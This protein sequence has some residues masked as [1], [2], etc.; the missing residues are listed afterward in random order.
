MTNRCKKL[1]LVNYS[2]SI[3]KILPTKTGTPIQTLSS[4][5]IL[6]HKTGVKKKQ[7]FVNHFILPDITPEITSVEWIRTKHKWIATHCSVT[8]L[9]LN[10]LC[11][12]KSVE[13][14][15]VYVWKRV[16]QVSTS[17]KYN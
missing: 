6:R 5:D 10:R 14:D 17:L 11:R 2:H 9:L 13:L 12:R 3:V 16:F 1:T 8:V 4:S 7:V 15:Y